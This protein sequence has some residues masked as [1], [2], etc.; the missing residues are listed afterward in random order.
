MDRDIFATL[1]FQGARFQGAM[2]VDVLPELLAYRELIMTVARALFLERNPAR[3]RVPK[4]F[5]DELRLVLE[6]VEDGSAVPILS[7]ELPSGQL[8]QDGAD[9]FADA[10]DLVEQ[11]IA[12]AAGSTLPA[13]FPRSA[14]P[15]FAAFGRSLREG[16]SVVVAPPGTRVGAKYDRQIRK[17]LL[18]LSAASYEDTVDLF[19]EVRSA[20]KDIEGFALRLPDG[21]RVDVR[22]PSHLFPVAMQSMIDES[23]VMRVR[24]VGLFNADGALQRVA[25]A[26]DVRLADEGEEP[27]PSS[28][29]CSTPVEGQIVTLESLHTGWLDG[30]GK[31]YDSAQLA[32]L[33]KLLT[34][35]VDSFGLPT[36]Y[37]YPDPEGLVRAEWSQSAW[38]IVATFDLAT[39]SAEMLAV[40]A[41]SQQVHETALQFDEAGAES[42]LGKFVQRFVAAG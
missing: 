9:V 8:F 41:E 7:R 4:G 24:G 13:T 28:R 19:G 40:H 36:P 35:V 31:S 42:Q 15:K 21:T 22:S 33:N 1:V 39:K 17:N 20:D 37:I 27:V 3:T 25:I 5:E 34:N 2:P 38:E 11:G 26:T 30:G 14:L 18:L 6:K 12:A 32:W 16:E 29:G 23:T 10:R